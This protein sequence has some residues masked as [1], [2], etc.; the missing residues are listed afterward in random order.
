MQVSTVDTLPADELRM[1]VRSTEV[2]PSSPSD[3]HP[4]YAT[5]GRIPLKT[6]PTRH[7][8]AIV[9]LSTGAARPPCST[10]PW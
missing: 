4:A 2:T 6:S 10:S 1:V 9:A 8:R 3:Y 5:R 7:G